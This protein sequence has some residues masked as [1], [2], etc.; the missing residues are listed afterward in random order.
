[1]SKTGVHKNIHYDRRHCMKVH[2]ISPATGHA[3]TLDMTKVALV[4]AKAAA[5]M[6]VDTEERSELG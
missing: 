1:M 4:K 5:I 6:S 3:T 2:L